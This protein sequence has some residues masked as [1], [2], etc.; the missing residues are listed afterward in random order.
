M[1]SVDTPLLY[2]SVSLVEFGAMCHVLRARRRVA[3][4]LPWPATH[5]R[6][7]ALPAVAIDD[8]F[9][10]RCAHLSMSA[11]GISLSTLNLA[12]SDDDVLFQPPSVIYPDRSSFSQALEVATRKLSIAHTR[13]TN[14]RYDLA[15]PLYL[16]CA[17]GFLWAHRNVRS[18]GL[19]E[20]RLIKLREN[21]ARQTQKALERAERIKAVKGIDWAKRFSGAQRRL[22][23]GAQRVARGLWPREQPKS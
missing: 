18:A 4:A 20:D 8:V 6:P 22:D 1:W 12:D 13:E 5:R 9:L 11:V 19:Q 3:R 14:A 2:R 16:S 17:T 21:L 7:N 15:Y 23:I 10:C